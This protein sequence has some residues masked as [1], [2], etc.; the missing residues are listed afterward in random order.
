MIRTTTSCAFVF[1]SI[2]A[3]LPCMAQT[4]GYPVRSVRYMVSGSPG[5]GTDILGRIIAERLSAGL[6]QQ[7]I[8][9]NR[10]GGGS[11]I[12]A[13]LVAKSPPDGHTLLQM[14][15]TLALNVTLYKNLSYDLF[16][17]LAP[18]T[19]LATAPSVVVVHPSLPASSIRELVR[20]AKARPGQIDYASGG[21]GTSSFLAVELFKGQASIDLT[22]VPYKGGGLVLNA[23]LSGET[24][25]SFLPVSTALPPVKRGALRALA[26]TSKSRLALAPTIPTV[27]ESGM[28]GFESGNWY[29]L[30]VAAKTPRS[31]INTIRSAAVAG[32]S[33]PS[34]NNR[35]SDLGYIVVGDQPDEFGAYIK[36]EAERLGKVVRAFNLA[37]D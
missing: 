5:S 9:D 35:L 13:E 34:V 23:V 33:A 22:H 17:D 27:D 37:A 1:L 25:L 2:H 26:V 12:A 7:V 24:P 30:V 20:L 32:M 31:V 6:G 4:Q 19:Q 15:I 3:A 10:P 14:T 36:S 29:G 21:T 11:N 28:P 8:V 16:R 18:V